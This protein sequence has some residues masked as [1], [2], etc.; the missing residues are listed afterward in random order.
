[1]GYCWCRASLDSDVLWPSTSRCHQR[2][3]GVLVLVERSSQLQEFDRLFQECQEGKGG[4]SLISGPVASGKTE[5]LKVFVE[6]AVAA[7]ATVLEAVGSARERDLP[8]GVLDQLCSA[9]PVPTD[10]QRLG[11]LLSDSASRLPESGDDS[12]G[13]LRNRANQEL[14]ATVGRLAE[15]APVVIA[16]DDLQFAD[17][18]SLQSLLYIC[19]QLR[20]ARVLIMVTQLDCPLNSDQQRAVLATELLRQPQFGLLRVEPL[21]EDGV[22]EML[23]RQFGAAVDSDTAGTWHRMSGTGAAVAFSPPPE[24][25]RCWPSRSPS[26]SSRNCSTRKRT[27][28]ARSLP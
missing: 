18:T 22:R 14:W 2:I 24:V 7:G 12:P 20:S 4:V 19:G 15:Q 11:Q 3:S 9:L 13:Y 1:M 17:L 27:R 6:K 8:F 26:A 10:R 28:R 16:V 5:L 25:L 21:S 23:T